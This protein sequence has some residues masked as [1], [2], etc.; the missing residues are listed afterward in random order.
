VRTFRAGRPWYSKAWAV[1]LAFSGLA[2]LY[3]AY[4]AHLMSFQV[5]Y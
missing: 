4:V 2:V 5:K 1:V 3:F